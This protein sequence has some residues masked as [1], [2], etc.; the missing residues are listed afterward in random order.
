[1]LGSS[2]NYRGWSTRWG[3][4][5]MRLLNAALCERV[6]LAVFGS[7]SSWLPDPVRPSSDSQLRSVLQIGGAPED[8]RVLEV[9]EA[10]GVSVKRS[11]L[12]NGA[13]TVVEKVAS[14]LAR[15]LVRQ[16]PESLEGK[17]DR[18]ETSVMKRICYSAPAKQKAP[19]DLPCDRR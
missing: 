8:E 1:V 4:F 3:S 10:V 2:G 19:P 12:S 13:E 16:A 7:R 9:S 17:N 11:P 6:T 14:T 18:L 15:V 5:P